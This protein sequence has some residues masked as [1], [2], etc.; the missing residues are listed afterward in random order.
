M[1]RGHRPTAETAVEGSAKKRRINLLGLIGYPCS[2]ARVRVPPATP[3]QPAREHAGFVAQNERVVFRVSAYRLLS[4]SA[5]Y[6]GP[7]NLAFS[8]TSSQLTPPSARPD[9]I[10]HIVLEFDQPQLIMLIALAVAAL[11]CWPVWVRRMI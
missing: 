4:P 8:E 9:T 1:D 6:S 7:S 2:D 3:L 10:E 11:R 5:P